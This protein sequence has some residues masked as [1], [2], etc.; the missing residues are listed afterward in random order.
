MEKKC[1]STRLNMHASW[2][3]S[4]VSQAMLATVSISIHAAVRQKQNSCC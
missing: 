3:C 4:P 2:Q 1:C